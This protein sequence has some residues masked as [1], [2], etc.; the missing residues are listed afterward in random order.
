MV[1]D[2]QPD[3]LAHKQGDS[4]AVAVRDLSPGPIHGAF[5]DE[6]GET[7]VQLTADV[8]LGHKLALADIPANADVMEYGVRIGI[9]TKDIRRGDYVHIHNVRS[10]RWH[11]SVA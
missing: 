11:N 10:A 9:A 5:L 1:A 4:V 8:P 2:R 6:S 7:E 3:F